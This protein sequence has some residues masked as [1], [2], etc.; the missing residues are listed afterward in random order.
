MKIVVCI[1]Q[2]PNVAAMKFDPATK[3]L[4]RQGVPLEVSSF[5]LRALLKAVEIVQ[6]R[7]GEV[8]ALTMG[9]PQASAALQHCL[10]LGATRAVH[11][12]DTA[13]AGADTL[14]TAEALAAAIRKE[15]AADLVF[16]GRYSVDA[17]TAQVGPELAEL[18]GIPQVTAARSIEFSADLRGAKVDRETDGGT[19]ALEVALPF[20]LTATEDLAPERFPM[21]KDR[22]AAKAKPVATWTAA[23]LGGDPGRFGA[24]GSPTRVADLRSVDSKRTCTF[25]AGATPEETVAKLAAVLREEGLGSAWKRPGPKAPALPPVEREKDPG[26]DVWVVAETKEGRVRRVTLELLGKAAGLAARLGGPTVAACLGTPSPDV[27]AALRAYGADEVLEVPGGGLE[28]SVAGLRDRI[29]GR[30]PHS[31]LFGSTSLGRDVAP[32]LAARMR[33]GLTSDCVDLEIDAEG[34]LV[35]HKPAFGGSVVAPI[36]SRTKPYLATVRPGIL[37]PAAPRSPASAVAPADDLD[38]AEIVVG[39]GMGLGGPE[40]LPMLREFASVLKAPLCTTRDCCDKGWL[41]RH[42]QVGL[43]GR[44]IAPRLYFAVGI[45]GAFEHTVG[46]RRAGVIVAINPDEQAWIWDA[47]DYGVK[48]D[49]REIVPRLAKALS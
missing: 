17:E 23:D 19:E 35:Q 18:L 28:A 40:H 16:C 11:L 10:A 8:V 14:A 49:W 21:K 44:S 37:V 47:A 15:G 43:T 1:K 33:L 20:L 12:C 46:I 25:I 5:D 6:E 13:F 31:V 24:A 29:A 32:R 45:R 2:V 39:F 22:E 4:V 36:L 26:Q 3:T 27:A 34:R 42:L 30:R 38:S 48:A 41:P 7:G 9:P